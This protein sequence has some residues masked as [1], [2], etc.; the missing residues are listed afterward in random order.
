MVARPA[1]EVLTQ[2]V[3]PASD[4]PVYRQISDHLRAIVASGQLGEGDQLPSESQLSEH[5]GVTRTTVQRAIDVLKRDGLVESRHGS[6]A[7]VRA[8]PSVRRLASD[9]FARKHRERGKAAFTAE[10][11]GAGSTPSVDR[12]SVT[13]ERPP[14]DVAERLRLTSRQRTVVRRRRYLID[15]MPVEL[16]TSYV[17]LSLA[18]GTRIT[19]PNT[20]PGGIYARIE[21]SGH[22]LDHFAEQIRARMP[23]P[24][25]V[26]ALGLAQ[27]V[28]VFHLV[29]TAYD[30]EG[31]AVEVCDTV[32][33][34]DVYVL[35]YELPAR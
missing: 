3:D 9:R 16:A 31:Q 4:R 20:G 27:G 32:M 22:R 13:E 25:E 21:E 15:G 26:R 28:P 30:T 33:S 17:P 7:Y 12:I 6:G 35:D 24:D 23:Q 19:E 11:E 5:Y 8:R 18:K 1:S 34:T 10:V 29:R 14:V 2:A